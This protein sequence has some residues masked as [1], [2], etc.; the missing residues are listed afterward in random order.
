MMRSRRIRLTRHEKLVE[1]R[2][3]YKV[4]VANPEARRPLGRP[5]H[6]WDIIV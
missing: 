4:S 6:R 1:I 3:A 2:N 5:R